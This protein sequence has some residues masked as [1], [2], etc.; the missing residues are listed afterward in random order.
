MGSQP[1]KHPKRPEGPGPGSQR[2]TAGLR[3]LIS[4]V[5]WAGPWHPDKWS[6]SSLD[7]VVKVGFRQDEPQII[8]RIALCNVRGLVQKIQVP[9]KP[10]TVPTLGLELWPQS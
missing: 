1:G 8:K 4:C 5:H 6:N 7:V 3:W 9:E 2:G 10:G